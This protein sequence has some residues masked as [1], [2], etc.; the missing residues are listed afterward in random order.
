MV[1]WFLGFL[2]SWFLGFL[3]CW[4]VGLLVCW[5]V[6]F[7]VC[8][9]VGLLVCWFVGLLVCWFVGLLVCWFVGLLVCW[10]VGLL[11]CCSRG[12]KRRRAYPRPKDMQC[13]QLM[14]HILALNVHCGL[15]AKN[16]AFHREKNNLAHFST[17]P[18]RSPRRNSV[19][20]SSANSDVLPGS[21][22]RPFHHRGLVCDS[23]QNETC[24]CNTTG[25]LPHIVH[26]QQQQVIAHPA[27]QFHRLDEARFPLRVVLSTQCMSMYFLKIC[28]LSVSVTSTRFVGT[29]QLEASIA[30][31]HFD[32]SASSPKDLSTQF[33]SMYIP[34]SFILRAISGRGP[35][36][37]RFQRTSFATEASA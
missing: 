20:R 33:T 18:L 32:A 37:S 36:G 3:V 12:L 10:F 26:S 27:H 35:P 5:F 30:L 23:L 7:L 31:F 1:C 8:W 19:P 22:N 11:V 2:V 4:F 9:F 29:W 17:P 25:T 14:T 28:A 6:C 13:S 21:C 34:M 24:C 16:A 15:C